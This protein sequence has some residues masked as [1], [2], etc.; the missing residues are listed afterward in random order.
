MKSAGRTSFARPSDP[1][2]GLTEAAHAKLAGGAPRER[3]RA[4][5][6][7][8]ASA[9]ERVGFILESATFPYYYA[10]GGRSHGGS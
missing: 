1:S 4:S 2:D 7:S 5:C 9:G 6:E 8:L 10:S 3:S